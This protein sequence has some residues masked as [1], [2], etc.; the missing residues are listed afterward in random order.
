[1]AYIV[2]DVAIPKITKPI[3]EPTSPI[4]HTTF[5]PSLRIKDPNSTTATR[6]IQPA[7]V[8]T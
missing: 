7:T 3:A 8:M 5:V 4:V 2:N 1:M 6:E